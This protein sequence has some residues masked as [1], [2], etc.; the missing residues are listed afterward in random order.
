VIAKY[1]YDP[2][3]R[4]LSKEANG[5][6]TFF[7]Y[8]DEGLVG[9]YD[10]TGKEIKTYG[11]KPNSIWTTD[12]VFMKQG[13]EYYFYHNDHLGTPMQMTDVSGNAAWSAKYDSFGKAEIGVETVVNNLRF[14]GQYF[15]G[16]TGLYYNYKRYY[17]NQ[18]GRYLSTDPL[19][20]HINNNPYY[21]ADMNPINKIDPKGEAVYLCWQTFP[22]PRIKIEKCDKKLIGQWEF[23]PNVRKFNPEDFVDWMIANFVVGQVGTPSG[24]LSYCQTIYADDSKDD[25]VHRRILEDMLNPPCYSWVLFNCIDWAINRVTGGNTFERMLSINARDKGLCYGTR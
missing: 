23:G 18:L 17:F 8:A 22:H 7:L 9:E 21:Y 2:F 13:N 12:P 14:P 25:W 24:K 10:A 1:Y 15:D 3:G 4:R 16:E 20:N 5:E 11:Y 19:F 6:K